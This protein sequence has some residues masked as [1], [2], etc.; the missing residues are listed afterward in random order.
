MKRLPDDTEL[1][2]TMLSACT[3]NSAETRSIDA[4]AEKAKDLVSKAVSGLTDIV[5]VEFGG[6]YAKGTW[7]RGHADIDIFV[8]IR[9]TVPLEIFEELG[10]SIGINALKNFRPI[11][12]YS[13][14]PYVEAQIS[15]TK[16]NVVPCYQVEK[17]KWISAADR[18]PF[19]TKF[20]NSALNND[21]KN[22]VRI[23]KLFLKTTG[24]YGA[25]IAISGFS[26]YVSEVLIAKYD[27]FL[28]TLEAA[29]KF[30]HREVIALGESDP[31]IIKGFNSAVVILDPVDPRRNLGTAISNE[32]VA[33]LMLSARRFLSKPSEKYFLGKH[34]IRPF[35]SLYPNVVILE[36]SHE[37]KSPDVIWGQL[38]RTTTAVAKQMSIAGFSVIRSSCSTDEKRHASIAILLESLEL[39]KYFSRAG[40]EVFRR[41]DT[42][43]FI[44]CASEAPLRWVNRDLK[45]VILSKREFTFAPTFVKSLVHSKD[46]GISNEL[47]L[48]DSVKVYTGSKGKLSDTVKR[49][50]DNVTATEPLFFGT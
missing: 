48:T 21:Q 28:H 36:F 8:K 41:S 17:G 35:K 39:P 23:L 13:D 37:Q 7:L 18:S 1:V 11:L 16:I 45:P 49:T 5:D 3:P 33:G 10:R 4:I 34:T 25:E 30:R 22:H 29:S 46:S 26:G 40:P 27:S 24:I 32:N 47:V 19:H 12:R 31:D 38:K 44:E 2:A 43:K 15:G 50:V 20:I 6:S 42:D 9:S 14:H